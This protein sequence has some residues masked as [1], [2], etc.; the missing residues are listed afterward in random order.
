MRSI[1]HYHCNILTELKT[2]AAAA[3][4]EGTHAYAG[5]VRLRIDYIRIRRVER[6][7]VHSQYHNS[8]QMDRKQYAE[9]KGT[10]GT[11]KDDSS[12]TC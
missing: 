5:T 6:K 8:Y 10:N 11:I 9:K 1:F 3:N 7:K 4:K 2:T 12:Q